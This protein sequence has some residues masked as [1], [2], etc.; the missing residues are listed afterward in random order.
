MLYW[1]GLKSGG[2]SL[3]SE[4]ICRHEAFLNYLARV[5]HN[6][7]SSIHLFSDLSTEVHHAISRRELHDN[8]SIALR[9]LIEIIAA[10]PPHGNKTMMSET[11]FDSLLALSY[12][13]SHLGLTGDSAY[14]N[15]IVSA[16]NDG[17]ESDNSDSE[18]DWNRVE[19]FFKEK[20][21]EGIEA[22]FE[23]FNEIP[24]SEKQ[25]RRVTE[26]DF[27]QEWQQAF[28][29]EFGLS[30]TEILRFFACVIDLGFE[31]ETSSPH[32]PLSEFKARIQSTLKW[33][34]ADINQ[35]I[36]QFSLVPRPKY[37][38]APDGYDTD[39]DIFPW[40][41]NR[42]ISYIV[43]PLII[44]P[45]PKDD[46]L[47]FWGPRHMDEAMHLLMRNV[48]SGRYLR[49]DNTSPEMK[50]FISKMQN[51]SARSFEKKVK[52]WFEKNTSWKID[53]AVFISPEG[54]LHSDV[55]IGDIDVLAIDVSSKKIYSI[56]CKQFNFA[57]NPREIAREIRKIL[58]N[59]G[60]HSSLMMKHL[61]RD[62]WLKSHVEDVQVVYGLP[63]G[64]YSIHSLFVVSEELPTAYLRETPLEIIP[65]SRLRREGQLV[66]KTGNK[67]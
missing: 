57:R 4:V 8:T 27:K 53:H 47:I 1:S 3:F 34:D 54:K 60:D 24:S 28:K 38:I 21:R 39:K 63:P 40:V 2:F 52:K 16:P 30:L 62:A 61:K 25:E 67:S 32:L 18:T 5:H 42:R 46:P 50:V 44:G 17:K 20:Y 6:V 26:A 7:P 66:L 59:D 35:A 19:T 37:E 14:Y 64:D 22:K 65:I 48:F 33:S 15:L 58:G 43:R 11:D 12:H 36:K 51:D 56:E 9:S 29:A 10:E 31:L 49:E 41:Y 23:E 55:N 45:E 13:F